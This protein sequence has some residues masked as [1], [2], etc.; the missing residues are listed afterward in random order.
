M[1]LLIQ[2]CMTNFLQK[3]KAKQVAHDVACMDVVWLAAF[4]DAIEAINDADT[5]DFLPTLQEKW[6]N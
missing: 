4:A 5:S 6:N 2:E 3:I 1:Q